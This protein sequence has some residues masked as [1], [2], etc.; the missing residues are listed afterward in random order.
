MKS[1]YNSSY[2]QVHSE[3]TNHLSLPTLVPTLFANSALSFQHWRVKLKIVQLSLSSKN[4][5]TFLSNTLHIILACFLYHIC[6]SYTLKWQQKASF[7]K[8]QNIFLKFC[9]D[10]FNNLVIIKNWFFL[11]RNFN[12]FG[13]KLL[14][15]STVCTNIL[16]WP[17]SFYRD[18]F[19][20]CANKNP[21]KKYSMKSTNSDISGDI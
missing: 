16:N 9:K 6:L 11:L 21:L 8:L 4:I 12:F 14:K 7:I 17:S 5:Q 3:V 13:Y 15:Q 20:N 10:I 19:N 1:C 2:G 18:T